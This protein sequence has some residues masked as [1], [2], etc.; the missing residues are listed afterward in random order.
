MKKLL[1]LLGIITLGSPV[2]ACY[3]NFCSS[4]VGGIYDIPARVWNRNI[5]PVVTNPRAVLDNPQEFIENPLG[6]F[7]NNERN[8]SP[9]NPTLNISTQPKKVLCSNGSTCTIIP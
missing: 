5:P 2:F 8:G 4:Y 3:G 9:M 6:N 1:I 7:K